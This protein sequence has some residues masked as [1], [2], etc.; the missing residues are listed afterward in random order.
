MNSTCKRSDYNSQMSPGITLASVTSRGAFLT[1]HINC[2][3]WLMHCPFNQLWLFWKQ[4]HYLQN[5]KSW[6]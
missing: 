4:N 3:A 1:R 6:G 2:C 5:K